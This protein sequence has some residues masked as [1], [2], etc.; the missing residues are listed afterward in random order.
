[1][2]VQNIQSLV[3]SIRSEAGITAISTQI[4]AI[5]DVVGTVV[6]STETAMSSTGNS[7]LRT[8]GEPIVR[9]L[10]ILRQRILDAGDKGRAIANEGREDDES[11]RSWRQ[12]NQ[13]LPPIAF[14]IARET[15][16]LVLRV[17]V[18]DGEQNGQGSP[19]DD[20]S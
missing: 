12:W 18:I 20:F 5:A 16:E 2:L 9:K 14:E 8:Q 11:E 1:M 6:A 10:A 3:S 13:S 7:S 15:K 4:T 17:D 19:A